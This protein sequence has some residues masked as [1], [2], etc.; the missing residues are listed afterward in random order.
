MTRC[1]RTIECSRLADG[2]FGDE[3][4]NDVVCVLHLCSLQLSGAP[5]CF[6]FFL[7]YMRS[8]GWRLGVQN[9]SSNDVKDGHRCIE[10]ALQ[11]GDI[12]LTL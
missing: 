11:R 6:P 5:E 8:I 10:S 2:D 3:Y 9:L 1:V 4:E 12:R 7:H